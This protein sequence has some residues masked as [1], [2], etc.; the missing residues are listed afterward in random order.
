MLKIREE[1]AVQR[2]VYADE[3]IWRTED[4]RLVA[5]GDPGAFELFAAPGQAIKRSDALRYGL[6]KPS[7]AEKNVAAVADQAE[8]VV[9]EGTVQDV[10]DA[11]GD[12]KAR[13]EAALEAEQASAKPRKS[14]VKQLEAIVAG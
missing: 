13:A 3:R 9:A 10:L 8:E 5:D 2:L 6:V 1:E 4:D 12:D 7:A 14:L 11:V